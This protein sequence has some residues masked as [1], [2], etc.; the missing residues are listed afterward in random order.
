MT[1]VAAGGADT[2]TFPETQTVTVT[3]APNERAHVEIRRAG[4]V[5]YGEVIS[6]SKTIGPFAVADVMRITANG[7]AI[8]YQADDYNI[9]AFPSSVG[10]VPVTLPGA[11]AS[12]IEV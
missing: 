1:T 5:V 10:S 12:T 7:A 8:D 6:S 2:Y 4:A 11:G 9:V 3:L